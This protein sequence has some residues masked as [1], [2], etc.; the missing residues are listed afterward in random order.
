MTWLK[1]GN[2]FIWESDRTG[3]KNFYLYDF[4]AAKLIAPLTQLQAEVVGDRARR[5][6]RRTRCTTWRATATTT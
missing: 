5:R 3:F 1:D 6:R 2:R 4:K